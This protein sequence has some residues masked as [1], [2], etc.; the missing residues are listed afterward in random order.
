MNRLVHFSKKPIQQVRSVIEQKINSKPK[1][2]WFSVEGNGD[3]WKR[4]CKARSFTIGRFE[5]EN[6]IELESGANI[7][8]LS[9]VLDID[10]FHR[11]FKVPCPGMETW[12]DR[13]IDWRMVA[14]QYQGIIISP[15]IW[16]RRL[17]G[18]AHTWYYSWDCASGCIWDAKAIRAIKTFKVVMHH[19]SCEEDT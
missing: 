1:G 13:Y 2:F 15:Y 9:S 4:W 7:R 12:M 10:L 6:E 17:D 11:E 18:E 8:M 3:G 5:Y 16:E 19:G 14:H